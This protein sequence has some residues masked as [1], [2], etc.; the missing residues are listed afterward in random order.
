[1]DVTPMDGKFT[2]EDVSALRTELL[3]SGLDSWQAAEL[4]SSFLNARGYGVS[5]EGAR[6]AMTRM[7]AFHCNLECMRAELEQI[8]LVM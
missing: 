5:S 3:Q 1:M 7:D 8:A 2:A 4:V 6:N